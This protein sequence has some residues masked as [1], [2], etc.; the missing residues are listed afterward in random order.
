LNRHVGS[1]AQEKKG[2]D[3][4]EGFE[5]KESERKEKEKFV[6]GRKWRGERKLLRGVA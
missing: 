2:T 4:P 1:D 5:K 6:C 3:R